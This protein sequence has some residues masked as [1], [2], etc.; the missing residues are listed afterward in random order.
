MADPL[1]E[2]KALIYKALAH[3]IR[4]QIVEFL[5]A[6]EKTVSEIV[7]HIGA[8]ESNTSR[9]LGVLRS[10]G[11]V[12]ARKDGLNVYYK[13]RMPCLVNMCSCVD[14]AILEQAEYHG[15]IAKRIAR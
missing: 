13:L 1:Y 4:V 8:K 3:P 5:G 11:V 2:Q 14:D 15:K 12:G 6:E 7:E 9:H 10:A